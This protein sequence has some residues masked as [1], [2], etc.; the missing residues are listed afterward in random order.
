MPG[1]NNEFKA[2]ILIKFNTKKN[3]SVSNKLYRPKKSKSI[4]FFKAGKLKCI[5]ISEGLLSLV[6]FSR[7]F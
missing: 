7:K 6:F 3:T 2:N 4:R 1:S 5:K